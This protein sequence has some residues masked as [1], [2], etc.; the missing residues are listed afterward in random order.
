MLNNV[1][2]LNVG[3]SLEWWK[4]S[5]NTHHSVTNSVSHDPDIQHL[6]FMAVNKD[7]FKSLYSFYHGRKMNFDKAGA[8]FVSKQHY[9]FYVIM[10]LA[11]FNLYAQSFIFNLAGPGSRTGKKR[12]E[13]VSLAFFWMW[14]VSLLSYSTS[15]LHGLVFMLVSHA[16]AGI[17]HVQICINHFPMDTYNGIP[18]KAFAEDG[19]LMSQLTTTRNIECAPF[20]D[21]FHGG[22]Q[23]Q[24]E[25]HIFPHLT[26]SRLRYVQEHLRELCMKHNLPYQS[27]PFWKANW[28][29]LI[30]LYETSKELHIADVIIDGLNLNG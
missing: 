13:L 27:V 20:M 8:F 22:L 7:L 6:P 11:R 25:H 9:L 4:H 30:C 12:R 21:F 17:V 26:R 16:V 23:F 3:I 18:Q 15:W 2:C 19:Y 10:A 28:D 14:Y 29:V 1:F 5:H 24:I